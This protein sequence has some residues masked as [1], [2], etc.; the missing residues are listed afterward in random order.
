MGRSGCN[1]RSCRMGLLGCR[2]FFRSPTCELVPPVRPDTREPCRIGE[3]VLIEA[4]MAILKWPIKGAR[5]INLR[6]DNQNVLSRGEAAISHAPAANSSV[7]SFHLVCLTRHVDIAQVYVRSEHNIIAD[8]LTRRPE[9]G[10]GDLSF[11]EGTA[12]VNAAGELW[13]NMA[14]P[15]KATPLPPT[16][17][18][19]F[20]TLAEILH[21][22]RF[23][24]STAFANGCQAI[25]RSHDC[26][27][28]GVYPF[29]ATNYLE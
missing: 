27:G 11:Q 10:V 6:T 8:G 12:R 1:A 21:F 9:H 23:T 4:T 13:A 17:T 20:A 22:P 14:L 18:G 3:C 26:W 29:D 16:V 28:T 7:R 24:T 5:N 25:S 19:N 15:Y 2:E